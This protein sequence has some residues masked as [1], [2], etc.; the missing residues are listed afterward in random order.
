MQTRVHKIGLCINLGQN[1][2]RGEKQTEHTRAGETL[3]EPGPTN[4][5]QG[6]R[7]SEIK[8]R[9]K[10]SPPIHPMFKSRDGQ[11]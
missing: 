5:N 3:W 9:G 10:I 11:G 8:K 2:E 4:L 7:K 6:K 1:R